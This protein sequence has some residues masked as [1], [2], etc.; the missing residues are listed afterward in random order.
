MISF[1]L[2]KLKKI[3]L[4]LSFYVSLLNEK[5]LFYIYS[6]KWRHFENVLYCNTNDLHSIAQLTCT[7]Y[8]NDLHLEHKGLAQTHT[9][10]APPQI[11]ILKPRE[12]FKMVLLCRWPTLSVNISSTLTVTT[13]YWV[14]NRNNMRRGYSDS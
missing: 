2:N 6:V 7:N 10:L 8:T 1:Y 4:C 13:C 14:C 5:T 11:N 9:W 3:S 12:S